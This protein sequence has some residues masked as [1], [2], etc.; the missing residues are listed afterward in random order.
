MHERTGSGEVV[1]CGTG[2]M[3]PSGVL[4]DADAEDVRRLRFSDPAVEAAFRADYD[5]KALVPV[6]QFL[7]IAG[8]LY[9]ALGL[10]D[11]D[12]TVRGAGPLIRDFLHQVICPM[13]LGFLL[14]SYTRV[15]ARLMERPSRC[16][17]RSPAAG[18]RCSRR[19]RTRRW[20]TRISRC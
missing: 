14:L 20:R 3:G 6:R 11:G 15:F 13:A 4:E 1:R 19:R 17:A 2:P 12:P 18:W 8:T 5:R 10:V 7:L 9:A 16:S